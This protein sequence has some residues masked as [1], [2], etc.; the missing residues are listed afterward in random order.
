[1]AA[2]TA[3][4]AVPLTEPGSKLRLGRRRRAHHH[5][6]QPQGDVAHPRGDHVQHDPTDHLRADVP[7]RV[8]RVDRPAG[9]PV[10]RRL[11]DARRLRADRRVRRHEHRHRLVRG[12]AQG[13]HRAVPFAAHVAVGGARRPGAVRPRAQ[14]RRRAP[15]DRRRV[16]GRL[17]G[18]HGRGAVRGVDR[19]VAAVLLRLLVDLRPHRAAGAQRRVR[20]GRV[21]PD[22]RPAGVRVDAPS[23]RWRT[24]PARS[25]PTTTCSRCRS[26]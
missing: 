4:A 26:W 18:A 13:T 3:P 22:P 6:A 23:P 11:P 24:C 16:P 5:L 25:R 1:M 8:R 19:A 10:L 7:L 9:R 2:I 20:P 14:R 12:P 15:D 21:V 17:P